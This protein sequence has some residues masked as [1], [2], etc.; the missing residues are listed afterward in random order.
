MEIQSSPISVPASARACDRRPSGGGLPSC[1]L[2][3]AQAGKIRPY[4]LHKCTDGLPSKCSPKTC[5]MSD[6][7]PQRLARIKGNEF[8]GVLRLLGDTT[9]FLTN[10]AR[11]LFTALRVASLLPAVLLRAFCHRLRQPSKSAGLPSLASE[12]KRQISRTGDSLQE[13]RHRSRT[14]ELLTHRRHE[15][16]PQSESPGQQQL[17]MQT[18]DMLRPFKTHCKPPSAG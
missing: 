12:A 8:A 17:E 13:H 15:C 7:S 16:C 1:I 14:T 5:K 10:R 6:V 3:H 4:S 18:A 9:C 11:I 2:E